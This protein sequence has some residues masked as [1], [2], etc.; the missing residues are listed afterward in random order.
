[1]LFNFNFGACL[2]VKG[3]FPYKFEGEVS[4]YAVFDQREAHSHTWTIKEQI[5][6]EGFWFLFR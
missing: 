3:Y 5:I 2:I 6:E 1:M 4:P